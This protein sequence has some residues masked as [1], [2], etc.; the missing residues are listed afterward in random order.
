MML[1]APS[2]FNNVVGTLKDPYKMKCWITKH[3]ASIKIWSTFCLF[4]F[5]LFHLFS[6]GDFSFLL[7]L[8]SMVSM[9][10]FMMVLIKI[11]MTKSVSGVSLRMNEAY[12]VLIFSRLLSIIPFEGYLPFDRSGDWLYQTIEVITFFLACMVVYACRVRYPNTY[13]SAA[14]N[15]K[16]VYLVVPAVTL[17]LLFHPSLNSFF[18]SDVAWTFALY[19]EA[20][21]SIPQL[22]LFQREKKVKPFTV[23]F[24]GGQALAKLFCFIFW[25]SSHNELNDP[26]HPRKKWVGLWVIGMQSL[27]LIV[28]ADF[29]YQ[30]I[31]CLTKGNS[32]MSGF[33]IDVDSV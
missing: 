28:K 12:C 18:I 1:S 13:N 22:I 10:S 23:H 9:F 24:L 4:G 14:D 25:L 17:A 3:Q 8:S 7:T 32:N 26:N 33:I 27:Q 20:I 11:E 29:I 5:S 30:Y 6:D 31:R 15:F 2:N 16:L 19:L 21:A